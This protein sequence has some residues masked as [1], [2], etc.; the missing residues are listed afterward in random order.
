M[1]SYT[2][3]LKHKP[4]EKQYRQ[5]KNSNLMNAVVPAPHHAPPPGLH[6]LLHGVHDDD[7]LLAVEEGGRAALALVN[8][9]HGVEHHREA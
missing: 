7:G 5:N 9:R 3:V 1:G 6:D 4:K 8:A 2:P